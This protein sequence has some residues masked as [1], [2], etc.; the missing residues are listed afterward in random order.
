MTGPTMPGAA[1]CRPTPI[2]AAVAL[3][4]IGA[5]PAQAQQSGAAPDPA[6]QPKLESVVVTAN[7]RI[8]KLEDVPAS[9]SVLGEEY[10]Q[11]NLSLIHI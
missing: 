3:L 6:A 5:F 8:E 4:L 7:R 9:I 1:R 10:M 2:A 11:R